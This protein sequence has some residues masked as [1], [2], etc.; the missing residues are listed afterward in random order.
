MRPY[1][2]R[3]WIVGDGRSGTNL[4]TRIVD[5]DETSRV[6]YE[7]FHPLSVDA[8]RDLDLF[9]YARPGAD[10]P[11]LEPLADAVLTGAFY[12]Q[13][14]MFP[15]RA[16]LS[17]R[18]VVKDIFAHL[19]ARWAAERD[20]GIKVVLLI[21]H[22]FAVASSK[23]Q[24]F[25]WGWMTEPN[26][27]LERPKL[28]ADHLAGL[29]DVVRIAADDFERQ[30]TI[31]SVIHRVALR[32]FSQG[33][34]H[35]VFYEDLCD[36]PAEEAARLG[37]FLGRGPSEVANMVRVA[38]ERCRPIPGPS[39]SGAPTWPGLDS[40]RAERSFAILESFSLD[41]LYGSDTRPRVAPSEAFLKG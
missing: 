12:D 22:P 10:D 6:M 29:D 14:A 8:M 4:L 39:G 36:H 26:E 17:R 9:H 34:C 1:D 23:L 18:L 13:R 15:Q 31:W 40:E 21:R 28:V 19:F 11:L 27:F 3:V 41:R 25:Q 33:D 30:V 16:R 32:Q 2:E 5:D 38:V 37:E 20:P 35:V 24:R 7:P